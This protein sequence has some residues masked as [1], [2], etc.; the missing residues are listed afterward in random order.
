VA[1]HPEEAPPG[2]A[3]NLS[4][5]FGGHWRDDLLLVSYRGTVNPELILPAVIL[6]DL[7]PGFRGLL[8]AALL[9]ALMGGLSSQ[10]NSTSALFVRDIYQNFLR[11]KAKNRELIMAAYLSSIGI[12]V[13]GFVMGLHADSINELWGWLIMSLIAG[14]TGPTVL[15]LYW[16]RTNAWGMASGLL[17]GGAAAFAQRTFW[18]TMT[19]W[20]QFG[21]MTTLSFAATI[22]GSLL[23]KPIPA[24]VVKYFY[25]TTRPFGFWKPFFNRLPERDRTAWRREH[26]NDI[27]TV[28]VAMVWQVCL[29]LLPM[30]FLTHNARAFFSTLPIFVA[31][32]V[33]LYFFWW[34]NLPSRDERIPD[35]VASPPVHSAEEL[36]AVENR[37]VV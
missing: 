10:I 22:A 7:R 23:T 8:L 28:A 36:K 24:E 3:A 11:K 12:V 27:I 35:F 15:R 21:L 19:E 26:R 5:I 37:L 16:W 13:A 33:G 1:H 4:R 25:E 31:G 29:L 30:E 17:L 18:P 6:C 9:S 20:W 14:T 2:L 32:C 34:R